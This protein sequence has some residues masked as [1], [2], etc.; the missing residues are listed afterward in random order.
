MADGDRWWDFAADSMLDATGFTGRFG[1]RPEQ[2][3]DYL[4]LVGDTVDDIPG[5]PGVGPKTAARLLQHFGDLEV[6][7]RCLV[8]V[9]GTD[10]RG[11][12]RL[13]ERLRKHWPTVV[14]ARQLTALD[15]QVPGVVKPTPF[16]LT[17]RALETTADF[18][19]ALGIEGALPQRFRRLARQVCAA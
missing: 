1:V 19:Q 17:T 12:V 6:L 8:E 5:V 15:D 2:F 16:V 10:I 4:A 9:P 18:L 14:L 7:E 13:E 11:A 3:A